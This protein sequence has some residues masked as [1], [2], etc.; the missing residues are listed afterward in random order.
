ARRSSAIAIDCAVPVAA[1]LEQVPQREPRS[2]ISRLECRRPARSHQR[3]FLS[4][5]A[6]KPRAQLQPT[7]YERGS[8]VHRELKIIDGILHARLIAI[9]EPQ[10]Q[11]CRGAIVLELERLQPA[12]LRLRVFG[13]LPQ[14]RSLPIKFAGRDGWRITHL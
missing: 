10:L 11:V 5:E 7:G 8:K 9:G 6:G 14:L 1:G 13:A 12:P 3:V 2:A 4:S